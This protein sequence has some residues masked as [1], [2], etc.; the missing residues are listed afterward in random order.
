MQGYVFLDIGG[1]QIK[2]AA[3][4]GEFLG[5]V[6][7]VPSLAKEDRDTVLAHFLSI[8]A[9]R[10][11]ELDAAGIPLRAVG[12]AFPGPFDYPN[13]I[14]LIR[15]LSKYDSLYGVNL[16]EALRNI[17]GQQVIS[18]ETQLFFRHDIA[19]FALGEAYR[20]LSPETR[21]ILCLCV[22]TGAG[23]AFLE[24]GVLLTHDPRIPANGWIYA[25]PLRGATIDDWVSVRGLKKLTVQAGL[26][27]AITGKD[28]S[29]LAAEGNPSALG[30]WQ[31]FGMLIAEA[32]KPFMLSFRPQLLLLGG[33]ISGAAD[34]FGP[35]IHAAWPELAICTVPNTTESTFRGL[36]AAAREEDEP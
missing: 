10:K 7:A 14:C 33:Q 31:Q 5:P 8:I 17:P 28:L 1:T 22:G 6:H 32:I 19:S 20:S 25:S 34:F 3:Y 9:D 13:G 27:A 24:N 2:S 35:A 18:P 30:V 16:K 36:L 12:F 23:S 26:D 21:R 15:G 11:A 4:M 29:R